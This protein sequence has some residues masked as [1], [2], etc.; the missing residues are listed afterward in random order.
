MK[1]VPV[2]RGAESFIDDRQR[3]MCNETTSP[4]RVSV[5]STGAAGITFGRDTNYKTTKKKIWCHEELLKA[6]Q[7][8]VFCSSASSDYYPDICAAIGQAIQLIQIS[9]SEFVHKFNAGS[10]SRVRF[11]LYF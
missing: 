9:K 10:F 3:C 5:I 1:I 4:G 6:D 8:L 11:A 2:Q 7:T